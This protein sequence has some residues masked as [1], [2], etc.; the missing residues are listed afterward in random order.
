MPISSVSD[1]SPGVSQTQDRTQLNPNDFIKLFMTQLTHQNPMQPTD[2]S[3]ILQQMSQIATIQASNDMQKSMADLSANVNASLT[4]TQLLQATQ[5]VGH[6]VE[7]ESGVSPLV[8]NGNDQLL[9]GSVMVPSAASDV[10]VT[11]LEVRY[12]SG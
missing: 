12:N 11:F 2:S 9:S 5:L 3:A 10:T 7:I 6:G 8:K 1:Y 4:N